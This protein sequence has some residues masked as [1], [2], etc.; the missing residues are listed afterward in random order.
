[1]YDLGLVLIGRNLDLLVVGPASLAGLGECGRKT[2]WAAVGVA[3]ARGAS[4]KEPPVSVSG[5]PGALG[6]V[7]I[8]KEA[9]R[10]LA[11]VLLVLA[12]SIQLFTL[13][14]AW[15]LVSVG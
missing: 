14:L 5:V 15:R 11:L 1:M 10:R 3:V 6:A 13:V 9:R 4:E 12:E 8:P 2:G 7:S